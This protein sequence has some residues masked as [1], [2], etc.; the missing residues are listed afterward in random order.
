MWGEIEVPGMDSVPMPRAAEDGPFFASVSPD[1]FAASGGS[2]VRGRAFDQR[3][4]PGSTP[5]AIVTETMA[6]MIWPGEDPIG[7]CFVHAIG[8]ER[9][10][11]WYRESAPCRVIVGVAAD[12]R[13]RSV[14]GKPNM[15]YYLPLAQEPGYSM[16]VL[17]VRPRGDD[18]SAAIGAVR[19]ALASLETGLPYVSVTRLDE[20]IE[21]QLRPWRLGASL[22]TAFGVLALLLAAVGLYGVVA[23]DVTQRRRELGVRVALGAGAVRLVRLVVGDAMRLVIIGVVLGLAAAGWAARFIE[24]LLF[25]VSPRDPRVLVAVAALLL[26]VAV[27]AALLP[28]LRAA[29]LHPTE[30]LREE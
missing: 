6:R 1:Y 17:V 25:D 13:Y 3:D 23:Y 29:T 15:M 2:I 16:R 11:E 26:S 22:F 14:L 7:K 8:A 18:V 30:A 19:E 24:P 4:V 9:S 28:A 12:T 5:V 21:P 20:R 10:P 27:A